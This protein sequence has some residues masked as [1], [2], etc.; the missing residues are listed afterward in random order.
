MTAAIEFERSG[1]PE[2]S[3]SLPH[4]TGPLDEP[5]KAGKER[6]EGESEP[7][8]SHTGTSDSSLN[9]PNS[10]VSRGPVGL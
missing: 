9:I 1:S 8:I 5:T 3:E 7:S 4:Q 6:V 2:H 10:A